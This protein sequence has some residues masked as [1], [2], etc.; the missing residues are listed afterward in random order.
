MYAIP[1]TLRPTEIEA[2]LTTV[3][4]GMH[5]GYTLS[6][7]DIEII[8]K[9]ILNSLGVMQYEP[10]THDT[11]S[12]VDNTRKDMREALATL[13]EM[14]AAYQSALNAPIC[15]RVRSV[16]LPKPPSADDTF[17]P[18]LCLLAQN[19]KRVIA[20]RL[21]GVRNRT[22]CGVYPSM[23]CL[24]SSH[25]EAAVPKPILDGMLR[26]GLLEPLQANRHP[27]EIFG[28][29]DLGAERAKAAGGTP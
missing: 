26:S 8:T 4:L 14:V 9:A 3:C 27:Y 22:F 15:K 25:R 20:Y 23:H 29:S 19:D 21:K 28:L 2:A 24:A 17:L 11:K 1:S 6:H 7:V 5:Q 10:L 13:D 18:Y 16:A 12:Y